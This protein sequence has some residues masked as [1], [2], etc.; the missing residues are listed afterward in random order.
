MLCNR[1][2]EQR[3]VSINMAYQTIGNLR[4]EK[5]AVN[6]EVNSALKSDIDP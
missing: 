2:T 3:S 5:G 1:C 4:V 6:L